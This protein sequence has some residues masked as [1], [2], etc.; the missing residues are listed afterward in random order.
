M[1][2]IADWTNAYLLDAAYTRC[3]ITRPPHPVYI[4]LYHWIMVCPPILFWVSQIGRPVLV[5]VLFSASLFKGFA[6]AEC[7]MP[8][9]ANPA[10]LDIFW[11]TVCCL[12][13]VSF[14]HALCYPRRWVEL[15]TSD[16][17]RHSVRTVEAIPCYVLVCCYARLLFAICKVMLCLYQSVWY[18]TYCVSIK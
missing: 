1:F 17:L 8:Y 13:I 11:L 15:S 3:L 9:L 2:P 6:R 4:L 7:T 16:H 12:V 10:C 18:S 14:I 5:V